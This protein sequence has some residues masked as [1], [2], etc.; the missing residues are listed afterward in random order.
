MATRV[1]ENLFGARF[2]AKFNSWLRPDETSFFLHLIKRPLTKSLH[3]LLPCT[4]ANNF[5]AF[6]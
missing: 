3:L 5:A 6:D 4:I 2:S 1:L